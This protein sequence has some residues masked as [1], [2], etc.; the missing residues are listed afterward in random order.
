MAEKDDSDT[1]SKAAP[2]PAKGG[3][4]LFLIIGGAVFLI[5]LSVGTSYFVTKSLAGG[6]AN[7]EAG[8]ESEKK[9]DDKA[10]DNAKKVPPKP[11]VY[12]ALEP[13]FLVNHQTAKGGRYLQ[14]TMEVMARDPVLLEE[15]K[16]HMPSIRNNLVMVLS[17]LPE[18][19]LATRDGKEKIRND[20]L[21]EINKIL[22]D[23]GVKDKV[24]AV[25]ITN[26]VMQ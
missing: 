23:N 20:S 17:S 7:A 11:A 22:A 13:A 24:E 6:A 16:R 25:Y 2:A 4:K 3:S 18:G 15:V 26:F 9:G 5:A 19:D 10:K 21:S 1:D 12:L 14:V 8:A